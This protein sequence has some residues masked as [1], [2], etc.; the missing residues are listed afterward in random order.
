MKTMFKVGAVLIMIGVL[1]VGGMKLIKKR[2]EAENHL[3]TPKIYP[4]NIKTITP[5]LENNIL[6]LPYLAIVK[7]NN[8]VKIS[9]KIPARIEFIAKDGTKVKK[10]DIIVR[11]D[12]KDLKNRLSSIELNINSLKATLN[13]KKIALTN[14]YK[15]HERTKK[16]L[17]VKGASKEQFDKEQTNIESLKSAIKSLQYK[18]EELNSNKQDVYNNL[19]YAIIKAP[20]N[21]V[22]T[23]LSNVGDVAMPGKPLVEI[24]S[25]ED[26]YLLVRLPDNI[27]AD[28]IIYKTQKVKLMP[29]NTTSNGLSEYIAN[30]NTHL[31]TNQSVSIDVVVFDGVGYKLPHD[32]ILDRDGKSY[33]LVVKGNKAI[34][35]QVKIIANAQQGVE[36]EGVAQ[37]D[38]IVVAKQDILL[39]L[40]TGIKVRIVK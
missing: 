16:L 40:L 32:A 19:S 20:V 8:D 10:G 34:P 5:K 18:I 33:V 22:V 6:T 24:S 37:N 17:D 36:V 9:S 38:K 7:S 15:T 3:P 39:K 4:L 27:K 11:L 14:L 23:N 29:L 13:A 12:N 28:E 2:K 26:S 25:N 35:K 1:L 21:G 30:I 31:A